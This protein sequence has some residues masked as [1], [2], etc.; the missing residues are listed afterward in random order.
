MQTIFFLAPIFEKQTKDKTTNKTK[1]NKTRLRDGHISEFNVLRM[2]RR[3]SSQCTL[4]AFIIYTILV[5]DIWTKVHGWSLGNWHWQPRK[6]AD[7][8]TSNNKVHGVDDAVIK[9]QQFL[10]R[11]ALQHIVGKVFLSLS[12]SSYA[13]SFCNEAV[14]LDPQIMASSSNGDG[15]KV[16]ATPP[17]GAHTWWLPN[18][19]VKLTDPLTLFSQYKL[20]NPILLGSGGG[21]AV[22]STFAQDHV[23]INSHQ[24][25]KNGDMVAV[26]ISWSR[27]ASSV[28][29]ECNILQELERKSTRNVEIC[30]GMEKYPL[31]DSRVAIALKPVVENSVATVDKVNRDV[32]YQAVQSIVRTL[33]D[34][35]GAN[36]VTTDVQPLIGKET[37]S[38]IFID[39][40][41][42]RIMSD[43]PSFLDL[44]LATS[45]CAEMIALIPESLADVAS[46]TFLEEFSLSHS[47]GASLPLPIYEMLQDQSILLNS[48]SLKL[49]ESKISSLQ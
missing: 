21:G 48:E 32:Q 30:L 6:V 42:A 26:K 29:R 20:S 23:P 1:Q 36:I 44:A 5:P 4:V 43:P 22:F 16:K 39:M 35:L 2:Q 37:G 47:R 3:F 15:A 27:S 11:S 13:F 14:A 33:V 10:Q 25:E 8:R 38:V 46:K 31:D 49:I 28:E 9:S 41:E 7:S 19:E 17:A 24:D 45:F 12:L 34:M 40:T 18:G